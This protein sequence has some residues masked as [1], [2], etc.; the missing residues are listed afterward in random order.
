[1]TISEQSNQPKTTNFNYRNKKILYYQYWNLKKSTL[2]IAK[3]YNTSDGNIWYYLKKFQIPRR[4][5]SE[6]MKLAY[7][8]PECHEKLSRVCKI[9]EAKKR[10]KKEKELREIILNGSNGLNDEYRRTKARLE[11]SGN[12]IEK[13][14][15]QNKLN[16]LQREMFSF[17]V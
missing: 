17:N 2:Q 11:K 1:M 4:S 8:K 7:S 16:K 13:I 3:E 12:F 9:R 15:F 5:R 6:A 14:Y 10:R